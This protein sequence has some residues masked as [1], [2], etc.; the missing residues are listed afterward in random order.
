MGPITGGLLGGLLYEYIFAAGATFDG[1]KK[2]LLRTKRARKEPEA[3]KVPLEEAKNDVI[4]IVES[5]ADVEKQQDAA[6]PEVDKG[7]TE[8]EEINEQEKK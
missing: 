7:K 2:C 1:V 8:V 5:K 3:E 4:E 6:E